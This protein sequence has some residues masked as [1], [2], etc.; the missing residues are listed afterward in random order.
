MLEAGSRPDVRLFR[1]SVGVAFYANGQRVKYGLAVGSSDL[2]GLQRVVITPE[3]VGRALGR[4][5]AIETK[6][7]KGKTSAAQ[8]NFLRMVREFGGVAV[9]CRSVTDALRAL[10]GDLT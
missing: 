8:D 7:D 6:S 3:M 9:V 10:D 5:L 2:I 4:F 1:N